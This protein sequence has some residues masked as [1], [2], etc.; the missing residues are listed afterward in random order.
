M[1]ITR[2]PKVLLICLKRY[3]ADLVDGRIIS[4]KQN[5]DI[6]FDSLNDNY[7]LKAF[8]SHF[9][10]SLNSGH[11]KAFV[12]F[13]G[14][15]MEYSDASIAVLDD[16]VSS[17]ECYIVAYQKPVEGNSILLGEFQWLE[18]RRIAL[19]RNLTPLVR[20]NTIPIMPAVNSITKGLE[21]LSSGE[22]IRTL[23]QESIDKR[24]SIDAFSQENKEAAKGRW[25]E[26]L[27]WEDEDVDY[28]E[29]CF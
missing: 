10:D 14:K 2:Y 22:T 1:K 24:S 26:E 28:N 20:S 16:A 8:V 17:K 19:E 13:G 18:A 27:G 29:F 23:S 6:K 7:N 5:F 21:R 25:Y 9:G 11:Y 3:S 12:S 4:K 15:F